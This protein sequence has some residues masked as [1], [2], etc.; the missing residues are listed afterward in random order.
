MHLSKILDMRGFDVLAIKAMEGI[1][2]KQTDALRI[3][4]WTTKHFLER[5]EAYQSSSL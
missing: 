4:M 2:P 5:E 3:V 1:I